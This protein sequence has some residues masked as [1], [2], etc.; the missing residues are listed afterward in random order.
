MRK[1]HSVEEAAEKALEV[2]DESANR[3]MEQVRRASR[4]NVLATL[5]AADLYPE[6][7]ALARRLHYPEET[8]FDL[9]AMA[10]DENDADEY[11]VWESVY[12]L[13]GRL[14]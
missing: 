3:V 13:E 5:L 11:L 9:V 10:A 4:E 2:A 14:P 1:E 6:A 12:G 7:A 8:I